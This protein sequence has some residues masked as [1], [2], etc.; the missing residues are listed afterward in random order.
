[1]WYVNSVTIKFIRSRSFGGRAFPSR[2]ASPY[3]GS[4]DG[5][6]RADSGCSRRVR[7]LSP[8]TVA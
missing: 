8:S 2:R 4:E 7:P 3:V 1:V 6:C 5:A